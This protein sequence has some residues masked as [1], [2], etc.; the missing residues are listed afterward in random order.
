MQIIISTWGCWSVWQPNQIRKFSPNGVRAALGS[1]IPSRLLRRW[2]LLQDG[3]S[4]SHL[5]S[6]LQPSCRGTNGTFCMMGCEEI[7]RVWGEWRAKHVCRLETVKPRLSFCLQIRIRVI[8]YTAVQWDFNQS[9]IKAY[10]I[11]N[12]VSR[13]KN[14]L[15]SKPR[16]QMRVWKNS[17]FLN[18]KLHASLLTDYTVGFHV[19]CFL[20]TLVLSAFV[21]NPNL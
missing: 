8:I 16:L 1:W 15:N 19:C 6:C 3:C 17:P 10:L 13:G 11:Y 18:W 12:S 21:T 2:V 5:S 9:Y 14:I 4:I 7:S 20:R